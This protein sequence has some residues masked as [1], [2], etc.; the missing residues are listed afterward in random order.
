MVRDKIRTRFPEL[1]VEIIGRT[2]RG[3]RELE[4][5]LSS[6]DGSDFFTR[7]ISEAL[8][9]GEAEFAVHSLKDMS[10]PHFFSHD[11][12]AI[13]DRDDVRDLAIFHSSINEKLR[14]GEKIIIGTCSPRREEMAVGFLK[15]ALPQYGYSVDIEVKSIRG[16]VERR[17]Q[18]LHEG[19]YD[20]TI[21][22]T[23]GLNRLLR[24]EENNTNKEVV[25]VKSL[26]AGKPKMLLPLFE[27]VPAP[28][29]GA[30]VVEADPLN[31]EAVALLKEINDQQLWLETTLEK[32]KAYEF[33]T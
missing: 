22:A 19:K 28:F 8:R 33:G 2:S 12:F 23:A 15:N 9:K 27:C 1:D 13:I 17:L 32:K 26:L 3:D 5:P 29:Q 14:N 7:E 21:L 10:A 31:V 25:S 24:S 4:V 11:A 6:L 30:I 20:G 18:Q 16:N